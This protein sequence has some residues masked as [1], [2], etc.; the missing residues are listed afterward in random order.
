MQKI[1]LSGK[2]RRDLTYPGMPG[3]QK[4]ESKGE[5]MLSTVELVL[6][7]IMA[8]VLGYFIG[9]VVGKEQMNAA[10]KNFMDTFI[11]TFTK[12]EGSKTE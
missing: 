8:A 9:N 2:E 6:M 10:Y 7:M 1:A 12:N 4:R 5:R 11:K 3:M